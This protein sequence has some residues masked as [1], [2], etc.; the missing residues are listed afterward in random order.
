MDDIAFQGTV[1]PD[2]GQDAEAAGD[3]EA[4]TLSFFGLAI[5]LAAGASLGDRTPLNVLASLYGEGGGC[6][7]SMGMTWPKNV[8]LQLGS[9]NGTGDTLM[10]RVALGDVHIWSS[11]AIIPAVLAIL[12]TIA[13]ASEEVETASK[14]GSTWGAP[15][16]ATQP[17]TMSLMAADPTSARHIIE[18][19]MLPDGERLLE[20]ELSHLQ[21]SIA[22]VPA[23]EVTLLRATTLKYT[24]HALY[25]RGVD[26]QCATTIHISYV[27][28]MKWR[29]FS[30]RCP[31]LCRNR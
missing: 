29:N 15:H 19:L 22:H 18:A 27:C 31:S 1:Q 24:L 30:T 3:V 5:Q 14:H 4:K 16:P 13:H 10:V 28:R 11:P 7:G 23:E 17:M 20:E 25:A 9:S 12:E 6:N 26:L 21:E 8:G 2:A